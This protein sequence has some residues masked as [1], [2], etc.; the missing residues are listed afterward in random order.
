MA[1][2]P[3]G[4]I[5][6]VDL[7]GEFTPLDLVFLQRERARA[8]V[9]AVKGTFGAASRAPSDALLRMADRA[10]R[11]WLKQSD[12][13]YLWEIGRMAEEIGV[14]GVFALNVAL[15][16]SC[17]GGVWQTA[18]GPV[19][20]RALDWPLP[21]LGEFL[22][23]LHL[24]GK[25]GGYYDVTW[26]GLAGVFHALAPGRFAAAINQAPM[27]K[28]GAGV[29][30]DWALGKIAVGR[31]FGLPPSHLLRQVFESAPD[32]AAAKD[33]LCRT[34]IAVPA[35][36]VLAGTENGEGC[37]I[38]RTENAFTVRESEGGRVYA[39]NH[40]LAPPEGDVDGWRPRPIDSEGRFAQAAK[41]PADGGNF[42][43]FTPPIA[44]ANSR[45]ALAMRPA[46]G[47][48][49]LMGTSGETPVTEI[50]RLPQED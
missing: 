48:L 16:W 38:E 19:L 43:W 6:Y 35:I 1:D 34:E 21:R 24:S 46:S 40:F 10:S 12:N 3:R 36:F 30:G 29:A 7:R 25:A 20:R 41:L 42:S 32:Y 18:S 45:V 39:A 31:N 27:R 47:R 2:T 14:S 5:P 28:S 33:I 4:R 15:E 49:S 44:N 26:P 9:A 23:V 8:M 11:R 13:P 17:T 50:L 22:V 37:I